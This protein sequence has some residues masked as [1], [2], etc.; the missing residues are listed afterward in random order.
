MTFDF[1]GELRLF[2][3]RQISYF[4]KQN[5]SLIILFLSSKGDVRLLINLSHAEVSYS[6]KSSYTCMVILLLNKNLTKFTQR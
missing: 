4:K 2:L 1:L 3:I 5:F 6:L